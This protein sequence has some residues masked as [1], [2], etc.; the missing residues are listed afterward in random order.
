[1]FDRQ[2]FAEEENGVGEK[3]RKVTQA[4][5]RSEFIVLFELEVMLVC[6]RDGLINRSH[7]WNTPTF[8]VRIQPF[9][10]MLREWTRGS[11][12]INDNQLA[13]FAK[14]TSGF[15]KISFR[16]HRMADSFDRVDSIA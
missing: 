14:E 11:K 6:E 15:A 16:V 4:E 7:T 12:V 5:I 13:A 8:D 10:L 2:F 3:V 9:L 1:M